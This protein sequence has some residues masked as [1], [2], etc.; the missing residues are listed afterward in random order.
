[1][2][3]ADISEERMEAEMEHVLKNIHEHAEIKPG[4]PGDCQTC[5]EW[6]GRLINGMCAPCMDKYRIG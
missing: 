2:D 3:D 1:M 5:G 4:V 6:S